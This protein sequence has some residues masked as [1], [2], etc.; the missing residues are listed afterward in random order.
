MNTYPDTTA[1]V[2]GVLVSIFVLWFL[3]IRFGIGCAIRKHYS[4]YWMW[5]AIHPLGGWI[6]YLVLAL[7]PPRVECSHCGGYVARHF[8]FCPYCQTPIPTPPNAAAD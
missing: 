1:V 7:L 4:P 3:P 5:F 6:A 8:R 2:F